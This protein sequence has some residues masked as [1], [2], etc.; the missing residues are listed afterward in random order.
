MRLLVLWRRAGQRQEP[1]CPSWQ[2][3]Q[4]HRHLTAFRLGEHGPHEEEQSAVPFKLRV[5]LDC[6]SRVGCCQRV[7]ED[8]GNDGWSGIERPASRQSQ[9]KQ[10][11]V[12]AIDRDVRAL[13]DLSLVVHP[14][15]SRF[16]PSPQAVARITP[17]SPTES[18]STLTGYVLPL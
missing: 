5:G 16:D 9:A 2:T 1:P 12:R 10:T 4:I 18:P 15:P 8:I 17:T 6:D 7:F 3:R 13:P 14:G 11:I